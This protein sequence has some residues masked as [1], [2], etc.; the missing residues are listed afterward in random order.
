MRI[1]AA[2]G[3]TEQDSVLVDRQFAGWVGAEGGLLYIPVAL[4]W[5]AGHYAKATRWLR[6]VFEP[7]GIDDIDTWTDLSE[8][9]VEE[10]EGFSAVYIGGG[11]TF[12]LLHELRKTGFAAALRTFALEGHPL[13][14]GSA[15]AIVLGKSVDAARHLD[16]D[17]VGTSDDRGL[18]LLSGLSV[19]VHYRPEEREVVERFRSQHG[20]RM[21]ALTERAAIVV[22]GEDLKSVGF[23]PARLVDSS[24]WKEL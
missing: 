17:E 24:G 19:W 14:G 8:H 16:P 9:R 3:G 1:A 21:V 4:G 22:E 15:G 23:D 20:G 2:G 5:P 11:N 12:G 13:Y 10:L 6:S 7:L 18:D